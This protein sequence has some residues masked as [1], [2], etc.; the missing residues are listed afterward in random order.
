MREIV[1]FSGG[2]MI[3]GGCV[4]VVVFHVVV[5]RVLRVVVGRQR[6]AATTT[7]PTAT[8]TTIPQVEHGWRGRSDGD[9]IF[10]RHLMMDVVVRVALVAQV[11]VVAIRPWMVMQMVLMVPRVVIGP[12]RV[13]TRLAGRGQSTRFHHSDKCNSTPMIPEFNLPNPPKK[14]NNKNLRVG[15]LQDNLKKNRSEITHRRTKSKWK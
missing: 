1:D 5:G 12:G 10:H 7:T 15:S 2:R 3:I 6:V 13:K 8:T 14:N 11:V 4:V 9:A